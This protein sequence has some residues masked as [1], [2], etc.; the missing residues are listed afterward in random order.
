[1]K[2]VFFNILWWNCIKNIVLKFRLVFKSSNAAEYNQT[3][4]TPNERCKN[5]FFFYFIIFLKWKDTK[6]RKKGF[7]NCFENSIIFLPAPLHRRPLS[8][9][10][11]SIY[12]SKSDIFHSSSNWS[13][14][15]YPL[16]EHQ[17]TM[18]SQVAKE[19]WQHT[20]SEQHW[21]LAMVILMLIT[22]IIIML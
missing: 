22:S 15:H 14:G 16:L 19:V 17:S 21:T 8:V 1:M 7:E 12:T 10:G 4:S 18:P 5:I 9:H 2:Y 11:C 20:M 6:I 3:K 13:H